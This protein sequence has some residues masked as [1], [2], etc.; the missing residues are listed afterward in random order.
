MGYETTDARDWETV[1]DNI[2]NN[3][4]LASNYKEDAK[5]AHMNLS[6]NQFWGIAEDYKV[7]N[8]IEELL[9]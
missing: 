9:R 8:L 7:R 4:A 6:G 1:C 5:K 3:N 2:R